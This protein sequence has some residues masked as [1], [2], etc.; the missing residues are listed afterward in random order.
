MEARWSVLRLYYTLL[1]SLLLCGARWGSVGPCGG[2]LQ[3]FEDLWGF[4][5]LYYALLRSLRLY[6]GCMERFVALWSVLRAPTERH[7]A[8]Q[9]LAVFHRA[10]ESVGERNRAP[11][12]TRDLQ[13]A[14]QGTT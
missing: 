7:R 10:S 12:H 9:S 4:L 3:R 2:S 6:R 13:K 5:R 14:P 8:P 1:R 11:N